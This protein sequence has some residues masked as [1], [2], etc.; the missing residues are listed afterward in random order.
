MDDGISVISCDTTVF[1]DPNDHTISGFAIDGFEE[2]RTL[3]VIY[4]DIH[5]EASKSPHVN[6]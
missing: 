1:H 5:T 4:I 3:K 2:L 6:M